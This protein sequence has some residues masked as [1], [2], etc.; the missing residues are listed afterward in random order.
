MLFLIIWKWIHMYKYTYA[1]THIYIHPNC[2]PI[3]KSSICITN[4]N[5]AFVAILRNLRCMTKIFISCF[6][7][8]NT[9]EFLGSSGIKLKGAWNYHFEE[10]PKVVKADIF[11]FL[12]VS[13]GISL[14]WCYHLFV[15]FCFTN[16]IL[17]YISMSWH[18][19]NTGSL[20]RGW[21]LRIP[22]PPST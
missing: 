8:K 20:V 11:I 16:R 18:L 19:N 12:L 14:I 3:S 4:S 1:Y 21:L 17:Y 7:W 5:F 13:R 9:W 10:I 22:T 6:T 2:I 15:F